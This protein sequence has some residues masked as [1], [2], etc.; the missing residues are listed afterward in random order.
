MLRKIFGAMTEAVKGGRK[1]TVK[2]LINCTPYPRVGMFKPKGIKCSRRYKQIKKTGK[3][4][5]REFR[6]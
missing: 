6:R 1:Y 2:S 4:E 3:F 5:K